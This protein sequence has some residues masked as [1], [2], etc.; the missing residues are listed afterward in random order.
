MEDGGTGTGANTRSQGLHIIAVLLNWISY[1]YRE[2]DK[3]KMVF[4]AVAGRYESLV[5][6]YVLVNTPTIITF[7]FYI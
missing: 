1:M 5:M 6:L 7:A 2:E 3:W 4:R